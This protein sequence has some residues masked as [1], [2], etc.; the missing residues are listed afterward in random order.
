MQTLADAFNYYCNNETLMQ[1]DARREIMNFKNIYL[2]KD[3]LQTSGPLSGT[4]ASV[5]AF[6]LTAC[7]SFGSI[8]ICCSR[9]Y[10]CEIIVAIIISRPE[11]V[12]R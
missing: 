5:W 3:N 10:N 6:V 11:N 1:N 4:C 2:R 12:A 7:A 9:K 8:P